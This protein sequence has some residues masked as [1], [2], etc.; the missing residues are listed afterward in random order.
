MTWKKASAVTLACPCCL[1][2]RALALQQALDVPS[3]VYFLMP[4]EQEA[5][6]GDVGVRAATLGK[7][8]PQH[9]PLP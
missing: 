2:G 4:K 1:G 3:A 6:G 5:S 7:S 9:A 8:W